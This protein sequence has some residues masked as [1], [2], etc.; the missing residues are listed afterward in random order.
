MRTVLTDA[1]KRAG[2]PSDG[3]CVVLLRFEVDLLRLRTREGM[4]IAR[5]NGKLKGKQPKLSARQRVH[6]LGLARA[7]DHTIAE[8]TELGVGRS[9]LTNRP[10]S[11]RHP[12]ARFK[13]A[14]EHL[15][16]EVDVTGPLDRAGLWVDHDLLE[17][18]AVLADR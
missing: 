14:V 7:G 9:R 6:V 3:R 1:V 5:A 17:D 13:P 12:G 11:D 4:A 16:I 10:A 18:R 2:Y 15:G 8:L